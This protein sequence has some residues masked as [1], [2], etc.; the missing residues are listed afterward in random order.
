MFL[1]PGLNPDEQLVAEERL[2]PPMPDAPGLPNGA[3]E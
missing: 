2:F 1:V 3:K